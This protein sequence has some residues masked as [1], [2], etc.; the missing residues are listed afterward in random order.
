[1]SCRRVYQFVSDYF[2]YI[3]CASRKLRILSLNLNT[4]LY[5][6]DSSDNWPQCV[7]CNRGRLGTGRCAMPREHAP[8]AADV[9]AAYAG[10]ARAQLLDRWRRRA[11]LCTSASPR[12]VHD[13]VCRSAQWVGRGRRISWLK[14][15]ALALALALVDSCQSILYLAASCGLELQHFR[16]AMQTH[17]RTPGAMVLLDAGQT[18]LTLV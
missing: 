4:C 18:A 13:G 3:F 5:F 2:R 15:Q 6:A 8:Y 10:H 1:M 7:Q 17:T 11:L 16:L 9:H 12:V 14:R